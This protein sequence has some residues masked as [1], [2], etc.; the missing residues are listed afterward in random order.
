M[1]I[2]PYLIVESLLAHIYS[3]KPSAWDSF[4]YIIS[5][6]EMPNALI[7]FS[8]FESDACDIISSMAYSSPVPTMT[9]PIPQAAASPMI[10]ESALLKRVSFRCLYTPSS[11]VA[12]ATRPRPKLNPC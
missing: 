3:I 4:P 12:I 8:W 6:R 11:L 10:A 2:P 7:I 1:N 5:E 9:R